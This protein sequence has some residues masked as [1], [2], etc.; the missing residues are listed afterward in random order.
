MSRAHRRA[1]LF[2]PASPLARALRDIPTGRSYVAERID[3]GDGTSDL[4]GVEI[5]SVGGPIHGIGSPPEGDYWTLTELEGMAQADEELGDEILPPHKIGHPDEQ[6]LV[7]NSIKAGELPQ[8]ENGELPAVGWLENIR[9]AGTKLLTD[10]KKVP[11]LVADL[12]E[13]GA[14]R[15]RS[16]ELSSVTS[17]VT[18]KTYDWVV[19]GL[20]TL[21]GTMPAVK[22]LGDVAALYAGDV[23]IR[24]R[25]VIY[26]ERALTGA[27]V[28]DPGASLE[29]VRQSINDVLNPGSY[30]IEAPYRYWVRDVASDGRALVEDWTEEPGVA[31]IV[32]YTTDAAGNVT[33]S[34]SSDWIKAEEAWVEVGR[35]NEARAVTV[36]ERRPDIGP[37]RYT[38]EQRRKFAEATGLKLEAVT[39]DVLA[40]AGVA[41]ETTEP[42]AP[43][44]P[45]A[46]SE[47]A[48]TE[49]NAEVRGLEE[50]IKATEA[51]AEA[52]RTELHQERRNAFVA[53]LITGGYIAPGQREDFEALYDLDADKARKFAATLKPRQDLLNE[54]GDEDEERDLEQDTGKGRAYENEAPGRLGIPQGQ[55]V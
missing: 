31:W 47:P 40:A 52:T 24:R 2:R 32:P 42:P 8:P 10:L 1:L 21:G 43:P 39:D 22:T 37:M 15:T 16:V 41:E 48:P 36:R 5:L 45:P 27:V 28:W 44:A 6:T 35:A 14:Y 53:P 3:N 51:K 30:S 13:K 18:G 19:T 34:P 7:L 46:P 49:P 50:R 54:L 17:Q 29:G 20:A 26:E 12:Y 25:A 38:A 55:L 11:N 4:V 9:V 33:V 23:P